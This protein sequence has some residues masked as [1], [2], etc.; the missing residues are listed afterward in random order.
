MDSFTTLSLSASVPVKVPKD[1]ENPGQGGGTYCVVF[2]K[3]VPTDSEN[4]G[5]GR[6]N[7]LHHR[8]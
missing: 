4:P 7:L 6:W 1:A 3:D 5:P 2:S 8:L